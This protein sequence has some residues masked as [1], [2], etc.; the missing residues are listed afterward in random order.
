MLLLK[1]QKPYQNTSRFWRWGDEAI[2]GVHG[3]D[4]TL[5]GRCLKIGKLF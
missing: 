3:L 2:E 4:E 1:R 5:I